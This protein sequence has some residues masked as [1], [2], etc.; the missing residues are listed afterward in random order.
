MSAPLAKPLDVV[1]GE[2][3]GESVLKLLGL[4]L[5]SILLIPVG[6]WVVWAWWTEGTFLGYQFT[7]VAGLIGLLMV[8]GGLMGV[9]TFLVQLWLG[10]RL[11]L[12]KVC[13]QR[14]RKN[15]RV[16]TQIPYPNIAQMEFVS[17]PGKEKYIGIDLKDLNDADTFN[18]GD[19]ASKNW[20]GW[21]YRISAGSWLM[22]LQQVYEHLRQRIPL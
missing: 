14:A 16:I 10:E 8:G 5:T 18:A 3:I 6:S 2:I 9:P 7:F 17:E 22:P 15:G 12:G 19:A 13:F 20:S 4:L 21:H 11:V 1:K